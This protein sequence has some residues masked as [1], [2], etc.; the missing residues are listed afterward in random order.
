[1]R[2]QTWR[3]KRLLKGAVTLLRNTTWK[4]GHVE[5]RVVQH[6][7]KAGRRTVKVADMIRHFK[8]ERDRR[9]RAELLD[10]LRRLEKRF[11]VKVLD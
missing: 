5:K 4:C 1:M 7:R 6:L 9:A 10:A 11:I 3:T 8:I 2:T